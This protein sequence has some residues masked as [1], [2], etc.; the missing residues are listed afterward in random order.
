MHAIQSALNDP[1]LSFSHI[2]CLI[3]E[4]NIDLNES[5][6]ETKAKLSVR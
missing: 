3:V 2:N 4:V 1:H 6:R 5:A